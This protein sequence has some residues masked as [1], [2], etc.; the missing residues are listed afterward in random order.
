MA[1]VGLAPGAVAEIREGRM[2]DL[3]AL[4]G[5]APTVAVLALSVVFVRLS[6]HSAST[7]HYYYNI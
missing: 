3:A 6:A 7:L 1:L 5:L 4:V 2:D